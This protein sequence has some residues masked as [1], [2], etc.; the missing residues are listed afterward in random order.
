M[1]TGVT[2]GLLLWSL[3]GSVAAFA[4]FDSKGW[5]WRATLEAPQEKGLAGL[6]LDGAI[7]DGLLNPPQDL[8][9]VD[10]GGAPVPHAIRCQP[11]QPQTTSIARAVRMINKTYA[12]NRARATLDFGTRLVRNRL[13]IRL[14][15]RDYL[16]RATIEG[17]NDNATWETLA[18]DLPLLN[19][20]KG[21]E[22]YRVNTVQF[23]ENDFRYLRLTVEDPESDGQPDIVSVSAFYERI[24]VMPRWI[25][26]PVVSQ[27]IVQDG[28]ST[29]VSLDLG[30]KNMPLY[31]VVV[32]ATDTTF[33]RPYRI[34]G[35]NTVTHK[36]Y[37]TAEEEWRAE[38]VQTPWYFV[39]GGTLERRLSEGK[40]LEAK[41]AVLDSADYRYLRLIINNGDDVPLS[42]GRI[43]VFRRSCALVI[44]AQQGAL[45]TVYGGKADSFAPEFDFARTLDDV[46]VSQLPALT[47]RDLKGLEPD[48]L[49]IPW[50][51][52]YRWVLTGAVAI[53]VALM[54]WMLLPALRTEAAKSQ[55][56]SSQQKSSE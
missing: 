12:E 32:N 56:E 37:R 24:T 36:V 35:R 17:S 18:G 50:S 38:E 41:T 28:K 49:P 25:E 26:A 55:E 6:P 15:G 52:R 14:S 19:V 5:G 40:V 45:Y 31:S 9:V 13:E 21:A 11:T 4:Q 42:I 1:K 53:V 10:S 20:E 22:L 16:R 44:S 48:A 2:S 46:D 33:Q 8:R 47:M 23:P 3:C 27:A 54:L 29:V 7:Y 34:E 30:F 51:E 39:S 43:Q